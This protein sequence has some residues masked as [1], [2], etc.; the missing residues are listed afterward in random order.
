MQ[1]KINKDFQDE[2][3]RLNQEKQIEK[4]SFEKSTRKQKILL[5]TT[6]GISYLIMI[7]ILLIKK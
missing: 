6:F 5:C 2:K 1:T 4:E 7:A 3:Q